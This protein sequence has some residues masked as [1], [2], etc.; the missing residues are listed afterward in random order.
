M[1]KDIHNNSSSNL[2]EICDS[3]ILATKGLR[4]QAFS[5]GPEGDHG[6]LIKKWHK[7]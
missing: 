4:W 1:E 2:Y 3:H 6:F 7:N 5:G